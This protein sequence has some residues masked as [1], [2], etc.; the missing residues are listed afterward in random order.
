M[1]Q[2]DTAG[3]PP[4]ARQG[5][6]ESD[7]DA[8]VVSPLLV[9]LAVALLGLSVAGYALGWVDRARESIAD[10]GVWA[11]I[12]YLVLKIITW[13]IAPLRIPGL[14]VAGGLFFGIWQGAAL[15][16]V[17]ETL[18]GSAN[19]LIARVLGQSVVTRVA[20]RKA[21][22]QVEAL[23]RRVGGWRGVLFA[24]LTLPGYDYVS[25]AAGLS[26]LSFK[27]YFLVTVVAGIPSALAGV[28][29]GAAFGEDPFLGILVS[30]AF[31]VL[32]GV[33]F[34]VVWFYRHRLSRATLGRNEHGA[35]PPTGLA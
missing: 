13:V 4:T 16:I 35:P 24:R 9:L 5:S 23:S 10:A 7:I 22:G 1:D 11:P 18:A 19:F 2:S 33:G 20:G 30:V 21:L 3:R 26:S 28:T 25:Y 14:T 17:G 32:Y 12:I 27:E 15:T 8:P 34:S 6:E 31:A 29:I